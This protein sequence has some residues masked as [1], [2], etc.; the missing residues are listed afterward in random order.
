MAYSPKMKD[1]LLKRLFKTKMTIEEIE[2]EFGISDNTLLGWIKERVTEILGKDIFHESD[3]PP[4]HSS[5]TARDK[6]VM[7]AESMGM[8]ESE[9]G[10]YPKSKV[11][12][13][14]ELEK[15]LLESQNDLDSDN[16]GG[17]HNLTVQELY[18]SIIAIDKELAAKNEA[19][20]KY[21]ALDERRKK[22]IR[23]KRKKK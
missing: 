10:K 15:R 8:T 1:A 19:L 14:G 20:T 7:G 13:V 21:V 6:V 16:K 22:I 18:D 12:T 3:A 5:Y 2:N 9:I 4:D 17:Q 23:G 11:I